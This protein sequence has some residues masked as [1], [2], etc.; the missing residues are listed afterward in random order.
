MI[1]HYILDAENHPVE[2]SMLEWAMWYEESSNRII[3]QDNTRLHAIS[4]VFLGLDYR[5][6]GKGPPLLFE[7]MV[8]KRQ[9]EIRE[10]CGRLERVHEEV[11]MWRYASL[12]DALAGHKAT[13]RRYELIAADTEVDGAKE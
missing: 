5:W 8:F 12:D 7:T 6:D 11:D 4:T 13:L 9:T 10:I 3:A 2:V 1:K